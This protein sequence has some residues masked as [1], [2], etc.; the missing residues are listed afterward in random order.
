MA[1]PLSSSTARR[2][3]GGPTGIGGRGFYGAHLL[4]EA[5]AKPR[6]QSENS[7]SF[8]CGKAANP[9]QWCLLKFRPSS[10]QSSDRDAQVGMFE[11]EVL[12]RG[13]A[14]FGSA[15]SRPSRSA[16]RPAPSAWPAWHP[17]PPA[18]F[19][20]SLATPSPTPSPP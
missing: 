7:Q 1:R 16:A 10:S 15:V 11:I 18:P 8:Q 9:G 2:Q 20:S 17:P 14:R 12:A 5:V 19:S 4:R 13:H 6:E 3:F